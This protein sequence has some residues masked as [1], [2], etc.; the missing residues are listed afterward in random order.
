MP[1]DSEVKWLKYIYEPN[2]KSANMDMN[3]LI[4]F[5]LAITSSTKSSSLELQTCI[6]FAYTLAKLMALNADLKLKDT[7]TYGRIIQPVIDKVKS[8]NT[9]F[10]KFVPEWFVCLIEKCAYGEILSATQIT[11]VYEENKA[12]LNVYYCKS[13]HGIPVIITN[14]VECNNLKQ[15][16][17]IATTTKNPQMIPQRSNINVGFLEGQKLKQ[18]TDNFIAKTKYAVITREKYEEKSV[19]AY[20]FIKSKHAVIT[21][22]PFIGNYIHLRQSLQSE[23][24]NPMQG[25]IIDQD[26]DGNE[27]IKADSHLIMQDNTAASLFEYLNDIN[28]YQKYSSWIKNLRIARDIAA[29]LKYLHDNGIVHK[30]LSPF[31]ILTTSNLRVK[32]SCF[33]LEDVDSTAKDSGVV[34]PEVIESGLYS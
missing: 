27:K 7:Q 4:K 32:L 16:K 2:E 28:Q 12:D 23:Y 25:V 14:Y 20:R 30:M 10:V 8:L 11:K 29:G 24:I 9:G 21:D 31:T 34:A 5:F 26:I 33:G 6:A 17:A 3:A 13:H 18:Q 19:I 15:I 22:M 1:S